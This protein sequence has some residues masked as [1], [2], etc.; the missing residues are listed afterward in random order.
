MLDEILK[1][2]GAKDIA[3]IGQMFV[4]MVGTHVVVITNMN[5]LLELSSTQVVVRANKHQKFV[6][7]GENLEC[8][9]LNKTEVT[10]KGRINSLEF[11]LL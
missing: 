4:Q 5:G 2:V 8:S 1:T 3:D 9:E 11:L 6:I 10:V 7:S